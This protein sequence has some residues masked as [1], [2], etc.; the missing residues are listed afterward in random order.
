MPIAMSG[1]TGLTNA[2]EVSD[3]R[4]ILGDD[5]LGPRGQAWDLKNPTAES[6]RP[7]VIIP[8]QVSWPW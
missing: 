6:G 7:I 5:L 3:L 2:V 4:G 8:R 1:V